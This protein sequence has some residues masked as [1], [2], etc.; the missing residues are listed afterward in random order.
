MTDKNQPTDWDTLAQS[1][2]DGEAVLVLEPDAIPFY[3]ASPSIGV[4]LSHADTDMTERSFSQL[5]RNRVLELPDGQIQHFYRRDN[6]FQF[7]DAAAK[8][9]AMKCVRETARA[10]RLYASCL[11]LGGADGYFRKKMAELEAVWK[12]RVE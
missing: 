8:Q 9:S 10:R 11:R 6:L 12:E 5:S 3:P 1:I 7:R 4:T 2:E